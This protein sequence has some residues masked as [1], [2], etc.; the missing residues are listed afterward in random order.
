[1][2]SRSTNS[3]KNKLGYVGKATWKLP[4]DTFGWVKFKSK[5]PNLI[6]LGCLLA[7][8]VNT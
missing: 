1:M 6:Y 7:N 3:T 4:K 5:A 2:F 8:N